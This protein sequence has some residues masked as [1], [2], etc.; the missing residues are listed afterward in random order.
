MENYT[1]N[2]YNEILKKIKNDQRAM[3]RLKKAENQLFFSDYSF[4]EQMPFHQLACLLCHIT[5]APDEQTI[6]EKIKMITLGLFKRQKNAEEFILALNALNQQLIERAHYR[7][8]PIPL[9]AIHVLNEAIGNSNT[10]I[11]E[12]ALRMIA[13]MGNHSRLFQ[14]KIEILRPQLLKLFSPHQQQAFIII[15]QLK[16][17]WKKI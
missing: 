4:L 9:E 12:W 15:D 14:K 2:L 3:L 10:E 7:Q 8:W 16:N 5:F 1:T 11:L 6:E 17:E 13:S